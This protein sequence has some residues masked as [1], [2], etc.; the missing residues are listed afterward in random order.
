VNTSAQFSM[1]KF[2]VLQADGSPNTTPK[3]ALLL[4]TAQVTLFAPSNA[5]L[6][7]SGASQM[8]QAE[9]DLFAYHVVPGAPVYAATALA[10]APRRRSPPSSP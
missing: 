10:S 5:A 2:G 8:G 7:A 6:A 3:L 9:T 1:L 4:D